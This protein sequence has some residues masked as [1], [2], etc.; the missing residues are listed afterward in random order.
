MSVLWLLIW[1]V[2]P[3]IHIYITVEDEKMQPFCGFGYKTLGE[4]FPKKDDVNARYR[5][6][7][8]IQQILHLIRIIPA[9]NYM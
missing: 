3:I 6:I 9:R 2:N 1:I 4:P 5:R 8:Y 7:L